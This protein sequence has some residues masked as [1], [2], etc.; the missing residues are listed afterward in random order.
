MA[1]IRDLT[2]EARRGMDQERE[3]NLQAH[4]VSALM[5]DLLPD[6]KTERTKKL[7]VEATPPEKAP[8]ALELV[9]DIGVVGSAFDFARFWR[10]ES[11]D[12]KQLMAECLHSGLHKAADAFRWERT[13]LD[14]ALAAAA[15]TAFLRERRWR[16]PVKSPDRTAAGEVWY[17]HESDR[18]DVELR[19]VDS[20]G[21]IVASI[22][23]TT[24]LPHES[25][26]I[27]V[28]GKASWV[29]TDEFQ[30]ESRSGERRWSITRPI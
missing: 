2:L 5:L 1:V 8:A 18:F 25:F 3:F 17:R 4:C 7:V 26:L 23:V 14:G 11:K 9:G 24:T 22:R 27:D 21:D 10:S 30:L 29:G 16:K 13:A 28:L 19:I 20:G 12:R 15:K 6:L